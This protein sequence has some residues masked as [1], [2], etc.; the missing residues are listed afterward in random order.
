M[1]S[2]EIKLQSK[3]LKTLAKKFGYDIKHSHALEILSNLNNGTH[4]HLSSLKIPYIMSTGIKKLDEDLMGG[5]YK[6]SLTTIFGSTNIGKSMFSISMIC[7]IVRQKKKVLVYQLEGIRGETKLRIL[8]NLSGVK[9]G[10]LI[11][12][13]LT[14]DE[15]KKISKAN[16]IMDEYLVIK[17]EMKEEVKPQMFTTPPQV[18]VDDLVDKIP[19]EGIDDTFKTY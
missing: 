13:N 14:E 9:Y 18:E 5:L 2:D 12:E 4:W 6:G 15:N 11:N 8:S 1:N 7:N 10:R 16:K 3:K 17:E 19:A